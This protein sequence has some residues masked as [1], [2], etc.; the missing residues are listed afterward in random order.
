MS[1]GGASV[2]RTLARLQES[3]FILLFTLL[4]SFFSLFDDIAPEYLAEIFASVLFIIVT[5]A[6]DS[7]TGCFLIVYFLQ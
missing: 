7:V 2:G 1:G 6:L 4:S 5:L 3:D